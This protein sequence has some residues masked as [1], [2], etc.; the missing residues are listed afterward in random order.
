MKEYYD[1]IVIMLN[2]NLIGLS[3]MRYTISDKLKE[4][5]TNYKEKKN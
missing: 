1:H 4:I 3:F 2:F 5:K